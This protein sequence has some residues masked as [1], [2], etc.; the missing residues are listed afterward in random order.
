M[1]GNNICTK[2]PLLSP[3]TLAVGAA[4]DCRLRQTAGG[5]IA[6]GRSNGRQGG[7]VAR[8]CCI[9]QPSCCTPGEAVAAAPRVGIWCRNSKG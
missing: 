7:G 4:L 6:C 8:G 1:A 2:K 9:L 5:G 3:D